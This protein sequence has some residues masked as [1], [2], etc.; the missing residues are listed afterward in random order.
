[1]R[2]F[3]LIELMVVVILVGILAVMAIPQMT[4]ASVERRAYA[5]T[6]TVGELFREARTRAMGRG[7]AEMVMMTATGA[8]VDRGTFL[9]WEGQVLNGGG[10]LPS[11]SPM[12]TCGWPTIWPP[13]GTPCGS[14]VGGQTATC[15]D[16]MNLNGSIEAIDGI[17]TT[18]TGPLA[19]GGTAAVNS[20]A[21][22]FTPLGRA[23]YSAG[24][25]PAFVSGSPMIGEL[26]IM[27][28]HT[29]PG[30]SSG[31]FAGI[32]RTIVIPNSGA[33]RIISH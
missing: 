27:L 29:Y 17:Q 9:L 14:T 8:G 26:Q 28:Q 16:G 7:A 23:Y 12:T 2:A 22:C 13:A 20:S 11:G 24:P 31:A 1:V 15:I 33:T 3:S 10:M 21:I 19:G 4:Y 18:I 6:I 30:D 25:T 32:T 5:D